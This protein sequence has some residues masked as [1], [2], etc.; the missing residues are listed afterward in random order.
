MKYKKLTATRTFAIYGKNPD[1][2]QLRPHMDDPW[3]FAKLVRAESSCLQ[4][5]PSGG[6]L[7]RSDGQGYGLTQ[8]TNPA[9]KHAQVWNWTKNI[10]EA[11]RRLTGFETTAT[12]FWADQVDQWKEYNT[13]QRDRGRP[14][15]PAPRPPG[16]RSRETFGYDDSGKKPFS[17]GIWIQLYN[18]NGPSGAHW[19][20]WKDS[21]W[22]FNEPE[23]YVETVLGQTPC[24]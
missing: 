18:G 23:N 19:V 4:F 2:G 16:S 20:A 13:I 6:G 8:L 17:H 12:A 7:P 1:A 15:V 21:A 14:E 24:P 5:Y 11:K 3:F 9:P 22:K 10:E